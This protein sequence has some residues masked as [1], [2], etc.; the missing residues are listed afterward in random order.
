MNLAKMKVGTR[1]GLG[2]AL[3]LL[4][5]VAVTTVGIFR[6][7]QIQDRLDHVITVN[8]VVSRLVVDMR[9]NVGDRVTSLRILTLMTDAGDMEPEMNRIKELAGKYADAQ[10]K[11]SSQF[12]TEASA[13]EKALLATVKEQEAI[14][15]PAIA[16][17]SELWLANKAEEAT[18]VLIK[19][20]RPAQKKWMAALDQLGALEDKLNAQVQ[21]YA[22]AG[23]SAARSF[24]IILGVLAVAI[25]VA[26]AYIITRGL[27]KQL[28]GDRKS[29]V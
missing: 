18:K 10:N 11:L 13:E 8:N 7:A 24:M 12:A 17:A 5:L 26:A 27:L 29:V 4:F 22:A 15:M 20:I 19:E 14:A 21:T 3:V 2:F 9:S 28:G 1:L 16:K 23:F 25:S 6:M